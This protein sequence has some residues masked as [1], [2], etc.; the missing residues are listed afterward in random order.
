MLP[1]TLGATLAQRER[2]GVDQTRAILFIGDGSLQMSVQEISTII[3][4]KLN[5]IIFVINNEGYTIERAIHGRKQEYNDIAPWRHDLT[6]RF[7][8]QDESPTEKKSFAA[9]TWGELSAVLNDKQIQ[10]GNGTKVVEIFMGKEDVEGAL[11]PLMQKQIAAEI[12]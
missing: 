4:Q 11:L 1:A 6:L 3:R 12:H 2:N 8:G 10:W 9:R 7:F 5:V